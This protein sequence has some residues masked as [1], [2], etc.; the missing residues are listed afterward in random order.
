MT[1]DS[2]GMPV[3][4]VR[5]AG[6]IDALLKALLI[7]AG[8]EIIQITDDGLK[9][10]DLVVEFLALDKATSEVLRDLE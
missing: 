3:S 1:R 4:L 10:R 5:L 9:P 2:S 6:A 8:A 7:Q